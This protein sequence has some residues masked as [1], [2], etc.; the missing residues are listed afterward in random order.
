MQKNYRKEY[1]KKRAL[2][3]NKYGR[4]TIIDNGE[5]PISQKVLCRC[6]C[7][8]EKNIIL[9][10]LRR[11]STTSCGCLQK[12]R[13]STHKKSK[14]R[15]YYIWSSMIQRCTNPKQHS[16]NRYGKRGIVVC[17]EWKKFD[18]FNLW[19]INNGYQENLTIDRINNN[20][21]YFP[22]NCGWVTSKENSRNKG[23]NA[24]IA[25]FGEIKSIIEWVEDNRFKIKY[26]TLWARLKNGWPAEIALTEPIRPQNK[27]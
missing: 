24:I 22:D 20:L 10:S 18:N 26:A 11:G 17:E 6:D 2:A 7:G 21:G 12:E 1:L 13:V 27:K 14:N 23:N 8:V 19:A 9:A 4:L 3:K 15:I 25:A 16:F 5:A